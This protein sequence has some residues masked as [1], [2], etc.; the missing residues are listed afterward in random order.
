M[1]NSS[2]SKFTVIKK[3]ER[4][5]YIAHKTIKITDDKIN[6]LINNDNISDDDK[7]L[8]FS[9]SQQLHNDNVKNK[10]NIYSTFINLFN[11]N[12][13]K[14]ID[15]FTELENYAIDK[16]IFNFINYDINFVYNIFEN[17]FENK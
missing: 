14:F 3:S 16:F 1:A 4:H 13:K 6:N 17:L 7:N 8:F 15:I 5:E 2:V 12:S 9:L 10:D 11:R